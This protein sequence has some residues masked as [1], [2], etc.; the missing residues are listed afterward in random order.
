MLIKSNNFEQ[1]IKDENLKEEK[2]KEKKKR[3]EFVS[4]T[5]K[6]GLTPEKKKLPGKP[7]CFLGKFNIIYGFL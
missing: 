4:L 3:T 5:L 6:S 7:S 1:K 2:T